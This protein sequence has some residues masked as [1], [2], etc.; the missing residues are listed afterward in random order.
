VTSL[1][2]SGWRVSERK[3]L[4]WRD[5]DAAGGVVRLQPEISKNKDGRVLPLHDELLDVIERARPQ[6]R[7]ISLM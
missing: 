4:E 2:L 7:V 1:Y 5:V 3:A 6:R